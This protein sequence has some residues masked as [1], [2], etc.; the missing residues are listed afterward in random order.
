MNNI[1]D[2]FKNVLQLLSTDKYI[3][4]LENKTIKVIIKLVNIFG[5]EEKHELILEQIEISDKEKINILQ[6]KIKDLEKKMNEIIE[7]KKEYK[8]NMDIKINSL[9]EDKIE[10]K[11]IW[12]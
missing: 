10:Y 8:K 3:I 5:T 9:I 12:I 2:I 6:N 7:E 1:V 4:K 11:K